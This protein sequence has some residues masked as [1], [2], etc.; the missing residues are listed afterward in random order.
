MVQLIIPGWTLKLG[1]ARH[2]DRWRHAD[3]LR[4]AAY[5]PRHVLLNGVSGEVSDVLTFIFNNDLT[6][7][8]FTLVFNF[9]YKIV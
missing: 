7:Q 6:F 2:A 4:Q 1:A 5:R 3:R 9:R 8:K